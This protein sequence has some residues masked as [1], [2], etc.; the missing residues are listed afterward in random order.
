MQKFPGGAPGGR[1]AGSAGPGRSRLVE[2]CV[3]AR[4]GLGLSLGVDVAKPTEVARLR[5]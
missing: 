2:I 1:R 4:L 3:F 5:R